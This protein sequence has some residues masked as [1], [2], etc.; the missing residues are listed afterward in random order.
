MRL[1]VLMCAHNPRMDYLARV[2]QA[3]KEQDLPCSEWELLLIDNASRVPLAGACDL[4]WHP[5]ARYLVE[6][7]V[8]RMPARLR[9]FC[10]AQ[11]EIL[12]FVDD[13][14]VLAPDYLLGCSRSS[15]KWSY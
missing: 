13:E 6:T 11:C 7:E 9:A 2:L 15:E 14:T 10:E 4:T 8:G 12:V 1:S 5:H 3:L